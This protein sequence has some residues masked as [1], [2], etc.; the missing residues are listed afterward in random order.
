MCI[1]DRIATDGLD[2]LWLRARSSVILH[3]SSSEG[4]KV[5]DNGS[6]IVPGLIKAIAPDGKGGI[7]VLSYEE[8]ANFSTLIRS[9]KD[10][11]GPFRM[12]SYDE[13]FGPHSYVSDGVDGTWLTSGRNE[14][15]HMKG[16][17]GSNSFSF[18]KYSSSNSCLPCLLYTSPSPRDR[19]R[20]R[21]PSSA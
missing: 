17:P 18:E 15:L 6:K 7:W 16:D 3:Y 2:G 5:I 9:K 11:E 8:G 13:Q 4:L 14:L 10:I 1:R 19:T 20:S 21:M 12:D